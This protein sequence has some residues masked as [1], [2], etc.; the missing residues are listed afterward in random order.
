MSGKRWMLW[1]DTL[2][3]GG[4][5]REVHHIILTDEVEIYLDKDGEIVEMI[6]KNASKYLSV[7]EI[8]EFAEIYRPEELEREIEEL[9]RGRL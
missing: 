8:E 4:C 5:G 6:V 1:G 2:Y 9:R 7:E 3:Y